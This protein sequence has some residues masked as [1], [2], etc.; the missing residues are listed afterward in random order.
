MAEESALFNPNSSLKIPLEYNSEGDLVIDFWIKHRLFGSSYLNLYNEQE[1][2]Y[3]CSFVVTEY[4]MISISSSYHELLSIKPRF[5]SENIWYHVV[6]LIS[7]DEPFIYVYCNGVEIAKIKLLYDLNFEDLLLEFG[8]KKTVSAFNLEQLRFFSLSGSIKSILQNRHFKDF[9]ADSTKLLFQMDFRNSELSSLKNSEQISFSNLKLVSSDAPIFP[10]APEINLKVL[11]NFYEIEW[12]GGDFANVS[13]Y[14]VERAIGNGKFIEIAN[15]DTDRKNEKVYTQ[16][17][18]KTELPEIVYYRIKQVNL[19]RTEVYSEIVKVG[20]GVV[21][22]VI[23]QQNYP[24]PFNP[25][26]QIE[27]ELLQDGDVEVVVY[28]LAGSEVALLQRGFLSRG[29][30]QFEFDGSELPSGIYLFQVVTL[31]STQTRKMI[32]TK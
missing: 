10:R 23:L 6:I 8:N 20:Q 18:E 9:T 16:L 21:E 4:Q 3:E 2:K 19:D 12:S 22:D 27:F 17:T 7:A 32:L 13:H 30:Y 31:Q 26:T 24:N 11:N 1:S 5:V 15:Q 14:L 29:T 25:K 28:N